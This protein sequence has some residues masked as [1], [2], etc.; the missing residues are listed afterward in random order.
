VIGSVTPR[1]EDQARLVL[2]AAGPLNIGDFRKL[3]VL[4]PSWPEDFTVTES[5][6]VFNEGVQA[7]ERI[8]LKGSQ[9]PHPLPLVPL[10]DP[11]TQ[12]L[13]YSKPISNILPQGVYSE[14]PPIPNGWHGAFA[15]GT[16]YHQTLWIIG[17]NIRAAGIN[18]VLAGLA[19]R[20]P[21]APSARN[22]F[23]G[24]VRVASG[25]AVA[26]GVALATGAVATYIMMK[27]LG[28]NY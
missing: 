24:L 2:A 25:P 28:K 27:Y 12:Y 9:N 5:E 6:R 4:C 22:Q 26:C 23:L 8:L 14:Y 20:L 18:E 17:Y 7:A 10:P 1:A 21:D 19:V 15:P 3:L 16:A 13:S 11:D